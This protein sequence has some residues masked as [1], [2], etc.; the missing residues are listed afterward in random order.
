MQTLLVDYAFLFVGYLFTFV[1]PGMYLLETFF[2]VLPKRIKIP[3]S[4]L[5]SV[6]IS[7]YTVYFVSLLLGFSRYSIL[8][9]FSFFVPWLVVNF[10][11][12]VRIFTGFIKLHPQAFFLSILIWSM[13]CF[14]LRGGI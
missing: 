4:M 7:T 13:I 9:S 1:V 14:T 3:L 2:P 5:L 11:K 10:S 8:V 12:M 6:M